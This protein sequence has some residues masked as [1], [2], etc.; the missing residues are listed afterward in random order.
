MRELAEVVG[1]ER[2]LLE[3][4][5][6][7][8]VSLRQALLGGGAQQLSWASQ[9]VELAAARVRAVERERTLV[10]ARYA[11]GAGRSA[12]EMTLAEVASTAEEPWATLLSEHGAAMAELTA[13]CE[14]TGRDVRRLAPP[15]APLLTPPGPRVA[16]PGG[17]TRSAV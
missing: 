14:T 15:P 5:L 6:F 10:T 8:L 12:R 16:G 4:L 3:L 7:K 9:E 1:R 2:L 13:R 11:E 17:T